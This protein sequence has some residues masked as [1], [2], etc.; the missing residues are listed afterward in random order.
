MNKIKYFIP[1]FIMMFIIFCFSHAN[2]S[3]SS[4]SSNWLLEIISSL[5]HIE[6]DSFVIRKIAH[7]SEYALLCLCLF[8]GYYKINKNAYLYSF[9]ISIL[10]AFT[11]EFHQLFISGRH[12][13][14]ID[15]CIDGIGVIL[16]LCMIYILKKRDR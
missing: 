16:M 15:V 3:L 1:S 5:L 7:I 9:V 12:G 8:Y 6:I 13:S 4:S 14:L 11:D 2:G 10:Y